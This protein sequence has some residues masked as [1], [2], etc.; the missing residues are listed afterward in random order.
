MVFCGA[1]RMA[2][3]ILFG[4]NVSC[5]AFSGDRSCRMTARDGAGTK[6]FCKWTFSLLR[7]ILSATS[8]ANNRTDPNKSF[9]VIKF[10]VLTA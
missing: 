4:M 5:E 7:S 6:T 9:P 8:V 2:G 1:D 10:N 3:W